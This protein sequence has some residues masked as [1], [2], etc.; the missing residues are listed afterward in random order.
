M[1]KE[2]ISNRQWMY[3]AG[4]LLTGLLAGFLIF[5][6][7]GQAEVEAGGPEEAAHS[8][9]GEEQRWT[10]SMHPQ[11]MQPEPGDCPICGMELIPAGSGLGGLGSGQIR[12][13]ENA[14]ALADIRTTRVGEVLEGESGVIT[15]SGEIAQDQEAKTVQASYFDGRIESLNLHFEGQQ[16]RKGQQ[17]ATLYAPGLV[18]AQ[19]ELLTA[20][21]LKDKQPDLYRAVRNK[22]KHWKLTDQ[23]IGQIESSGSIQEYFPIYATVSG[24]VTELMVAEGDY[25]KKGQPLAR[26][27]DLGR[28][29]VDFDA[30]ESQLDLFSKGQEITITTNAYP[31]KEFKAQI[32]FID[33]VLDAR[34]RTVTVRAALSNT[35]GLLKP[36]MFVTGK[37]A[38][39]GS[40]GSTALTV[41][42]T[43]VLWTGERSLVYVRP[44][45]GEP[46]FEMRE[47]ILG[48]RVGERFV[49]ESGL[50]AGAEIV[51]Q[52]TFTVD[53]AAQLQGK[54]SMMNTGKGGEDAGTSQARNIEVSAAFLSSLQGAFLDS[55]L[56]LKDALVASDQALVARKASATREALPKRLDKLSTGERDVLSAFEAFLDRIGRATD[57]Q[58]Q[59][60]QFRLFSE[61]LIGIARPLGTAKAPLYVQYCPMANDNKGAFWISR[62]SS[63]R[64]PYYGE[65]MLTCGEVR[66]TWSGD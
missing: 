31:G 58:T 49:I 4:A 54:R 41:P 14:M 23:Q 59:R 34:T 15:L 35:E 7:S 9:A 38:V 57:L 40:G 48:N 12:M 3:L 55:Y 24:T 19:Q 18:A 61:V 32:R 46:V 20:A 25:V 28:V 64:N 47:V 45:A 53:A 63:I 11:I 13:T 37:I 1:E 22:L 29:W 56:E 60:T 21:S 33:P 6:G 30:Y 8:H 2:R 50:E 39:E 43:A 66:A 44:R 65:A 27:T 5:G 17:L 16:I 51:T 52:G 42:A 26:L 62:D 10:C 36:G